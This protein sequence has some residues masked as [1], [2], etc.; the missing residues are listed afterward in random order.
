VYVTNRRSRSMSGSKAQKVVAAE[1]NRSESRCSR[2][3]RYPARPRPLRTQTA[4]RQA[5]TSVVAELMNAKMRSDDVG[6][7]T[8]EFD[9]VFLPVLT[10]T[11][12]E[13]PSSIPP[14]SNDRRRD[15]SSASSTQAV[16]QYIYMY[17]FKISILNV[18]CTELGLL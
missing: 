9:V 6:V 4:V 18:L 7:C 3:R 1:S 5:Q 17:F 14:R 10:G 15:D 13:P 8:N 11:A 2:R 12:A 16:S